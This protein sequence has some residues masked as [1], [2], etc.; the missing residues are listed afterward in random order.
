LLTHDW[1]LSHRF[2]QI[3][4]W[5]IAA[6]SEE[7]CNLNLTDIAVFNTVADTLS[8]TRA[9]DLLGVS[10]SAVSKRIARLE[11]DT[12]VMLFKRSARTIRLTPAGERFYEETI[13]LDNTVH[14]AT[15]AIR[16]AQDAPYGRL[17]LT[18]PTSLGAQ[19]TPLLVTEF[20]ERWPRIQLDIDLDERYADLAVD[21]FDVA[22]R[23]AKRLGDSGQRA[24]ELA[25]SPEILVASPGY[26]DR[27]GHP[28]QPHELRR[29]RCLALAK[30]DSIW[31]LFGPKGPETIRLEHVTTFNNDL[32]MILAAVLG[33]GILLTPR[34]LV[35]SEMA[36]GRLVA[37]SP[38]YQARTEYTVWALYRTTQPTANARAF[39]AFV[40]EWLP[41][42]G[43][44]DRWNPM[45]TME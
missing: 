30:H 28:Y 32:A 29:H 15:E 26:L 27:H 43:E 19:F 41:R 40:K 13:E 5:T 22:I 1:R 44:L 9:A 12:G 17:S 45:H 34:I 14:R 33:G 36:L 39:V 37:V 31:R 6:V 3:R 2:A 18:M 25:V 8:F 38:R 23:V 21:G 4:I 20:Q 24:K 10:R 11:R 16:I 42:L 35:E 7:N